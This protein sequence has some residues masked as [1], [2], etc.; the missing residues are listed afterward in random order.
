[1]E[2][3][4]GAGI[5]LLTL[6]TT[7]LLNRVGARADA[8][9]KAKQEAG[10]QLA[11]YARFVWDKGK[12]NSLLNLQTYLSRLRGPLHRAGVPNHLYADFRDKAVAMWNSLEFHPDLQGEG[13]W[14]GETELIDPTEEAVDRIYV[15]L[16]A[17]QPRWR[18]ALS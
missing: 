11:E 1:V 6:L 3:L 7:T 5:T 13:G 10:E 15:A 16:E 8:R 9:A 14:Y 4:L 17:K 18:R 12:E 2:V